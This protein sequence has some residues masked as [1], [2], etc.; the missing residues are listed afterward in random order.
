MKTIM[1]DDRTEEQKTTLVYGVAGTDRC[2]SSWGGAEGGASVAIWACTM[3]DVDRV[4]DWV[5]RRTDMSRV[6]VVWMK[7]YRPG[8]GVAHVHIYTVKQGHPALEAE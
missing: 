4:T 7:D 3:S 8:R 6:R 2:L 5:K 1:K